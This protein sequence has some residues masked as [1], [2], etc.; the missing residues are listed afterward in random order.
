ML[1]N[2]SQIQPVHEM[3]PNVNQ[4]PQYHPSTRMV[5]PQPSVSNTI[6][7]NFMVKFRNEPAAESYTRMVKP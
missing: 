5:M 3:V 1:P 4:T 7:V 6:V 2:V